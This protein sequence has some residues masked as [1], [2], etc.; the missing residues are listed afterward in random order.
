MI[1][2]SMKTAEA[3]NNLYRVIQR[4]RAP[5]GCPWD[6]K[7]TPKTIT[8]NLLE[9]AY[10]CIDE[11][12]DNSIAGVREEL[13]DL[14]LVTTL[15]GVI[16]EEQEDFTLEAC[17]KEVH[18]KIVRRHPHVFG[19]VQAANSE[20]A[21]ASWNAIKAKEKKQR[22]ETALLQ[23]TNLLEKS[24]KSAPPLE[25]ALHISKAAVKKGFE[26]PDI[27]GVCDKVQEELD[28]VRQ[29]LE[30]LEATVPGTTGDEVAFTTASHNQAKLEEEIGDLFFTVVNL[31]RKIDA[32]PAVLMHRANQKFI[33][34]FEAMEHIAQSQGVELSSKLDIE[35]YES[36]W[37]QAKQQ[38][39]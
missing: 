34:R 7:Q 6:R 10:E 19:D 15:L 9:E 12:L 14:F 38:M 25:Q 20:E 8:A 31:A 29:E 33:K 5:D 22:G 21:I 35:S 16:Y 37:A 32:N 18:D 30:K 27:H 17:L 11:I 24:Q 28:E 23:K 13:G 26:W 4:L 2:Q 1:K 36:Y 39:S 3:Y